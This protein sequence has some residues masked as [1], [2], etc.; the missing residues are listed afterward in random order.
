MRLFS[1]S[2]RL[3]RDGSKLFDLS[4]LSRLSEPSP[5]SRF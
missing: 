2:H 3:V 5:I 1:E 4:P